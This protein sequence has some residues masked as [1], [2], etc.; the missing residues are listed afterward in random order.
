MLE[1]FL[2]FVVFLADNVALHLFHLF[3]PLFH[4]FQLLLKQGD[5]LVQFGQ[6]FLRDRFEF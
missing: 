6:L 2:G 5:A 1:D 3:L 4:L